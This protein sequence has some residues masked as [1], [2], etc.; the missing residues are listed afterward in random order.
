MSVRRS[1]PNC[2]KRGAPVSHGARAARL[3]VYRAEEGA[4]KE[5][6]SRAT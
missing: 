3:R 2:A 5:F 4:M 6:G 1:T